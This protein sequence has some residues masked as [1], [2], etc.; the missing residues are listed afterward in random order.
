MADKQTALARIDGTAPLQGAYTAV[1]AIELILA[2]E[3]DFK[4]G[5]LASNGYQRAAFRCKPTQGQLAYSIGRATRMVV[6][7][8]KDAVAANKDFSD[9]PIE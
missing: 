8:A 9:L 2:L 5:Y 6:D 7:A 4:S 1:A 3:E